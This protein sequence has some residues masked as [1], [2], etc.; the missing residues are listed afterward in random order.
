M[1]AIGACHLQQLSLW[2]RLNFCC[3]VRA[4]ILEYTT[5]VIYPFPKQ[6]LVFLPVCSTSRLKTLYK[7]EKLLMTSN[8]SFSHSV[9]CPFRKVSAMLIKFEIVVCKLF[10]FGSQKFV[11]WER[12]KPQVCIW[13]KCYNTAHILMCEYNTILSA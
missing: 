7:K 12:V 3:R 9:F 8:F 5:A 13:R 11:V 6:A 1:A 4:A 10:Q 2:T